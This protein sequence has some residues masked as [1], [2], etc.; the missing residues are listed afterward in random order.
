MWLCLFRHGQELQEVR[1]S[2]DEVHPS[3][4]LKEVKQEAALKCKKDLQ[5]V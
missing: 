2:D 3:M 1:S 5:L 4:S